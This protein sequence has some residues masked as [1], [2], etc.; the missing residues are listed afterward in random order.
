MQDE[1]R[2][3]RTEA[4]FR[5]V[6]ERIAETAGRFSSEAA[7]FV[8]ECDDASCAERIPA[9]LG[10]YDDVREDGTQFLLVPGH[11]NDAI[12]KVV[13]RTPRYS[14]VAKVKRRLVKETVQQLDPRAV[15]S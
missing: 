11:E 13:E 14:I 10:A 5:D 12:E 8:C 15:R 6:N 2:R 7:E 1:V 9:S 3:A 4:L